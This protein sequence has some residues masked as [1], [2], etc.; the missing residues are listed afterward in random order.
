MENVKAFLTNILKKEIRILLNEDE[1]KIRVVGNV[2]SLTK[3]DKE[4]I[5]NYK[6]DLLKI[7][8][9]DKSKK[10]GEFVSIEKLDDSAC[11]PISDAQRRL[12]VLGQFEN[13]SIAYNMPFDLLLQG[14]YEIEHFEKAVH[15]T[16]ERHEIL[17][18]I[19][20][21]DPANP[22]DGVQQWVISKADFAFKIN[23]L[24][25][26]GQEKRRTMAETYIQTDSI[27]AF[28]FENGPLI[29]ATLIQLEE[30][31][32]VFY[33]NTHHI[34]SDG[35]SGQILRRDVFAFYEAFKAN[36]NPDLPVLNIQYRDYSSWQLNQLKSEGFKS[37]RKFWLSELGG[38]E[39]PL[40]DLPTTKQRPRL[41]TN[42]GQSLVTYFNSDL[43]KKIKAFSHERGGTLFMGMLASLNAIL[44]RYTHQKDIIIGSPIAGREHSD[45]QNQIGYYSNTLA[46]RNN[47]NPQD[48]FNTLFASVKDNT[49]NSYAHQMFPFDRLVEELDLTRDT[50]RNAV[51]DVMLVLQ[52][53]KE[54]SSDFKLKQEDED[55]IFDFGEQSSKFDLLFGATEMGEHLELSVGFNT[56]VYER[57]MIESF[58]IHYKT[59]LSNLLEA[60]EQPIGKVDFLTDAERHDLV[61]GLNNTHA[62]FEQKTVMQLFEEQVLRTPDKIVLEFENVAL[63]YIELNERC[64]IMANF[65]KAHYKIGRSTRLIE[66]EQNE[67]AP[68]EH[69]KIGVMLER[70]AESVI[71]MIGV[72]KTGACYVPID[73]N[74]PTERVKF[75]MQD[76]DIG[77][78]ISESNLSDKHGIEQEKIFSLNSLNW[79]EGNAV[80]PD[81]VNEL[82]DGSF[83]I[84]TSGS[85]G[86]PKGVLQTHLMMT[87]LIQW[88]IHHSGLKSGLKYLQ[89]A[90][91]SFD[92]SLHDVFF[93]VC[94]GGS[95]YVVKESSRLDYPTLE[96]EIIDNKIEVLSLPFS[97]LN[98]FSREI[99]LN[100]LENHCIQPVVSNAEQLYVSTSLTKFLVD[101]PNIDLHNHYGPSE[102]HVIA[103]HHMSAPLGN[104]V[105]RSPVGRPVSNGSAY[106]LDEFQNLVPKGVLGELYFGGDTLALGYLNRADLTAEKFIP[107]PFVQGETVYRSGD[108]GRW[109]PD[110]TLEFVGR[111]DDQIKIRGFR[112]ELGEIEQALTK[113]SEIEAVNVVAKIVSRNKG[114]NDQKNHGEKELVAYIVSRV[115]QN[116]NNLRKYLKEM[117]PDYMIPAFYV[118]LD[119]LPL[120]SNGKVDKRALP[121]PEGSEMASGTEYIAPRTDTE[122]KLVQ[123][124]EEVLVK[125]NIGVRDDFFALGGHSLKAMKLV[126]KI[127][128][129]LQSALKIGNI[130]ISPTIEDLSQI[131]DFALNQKKLKQNSTN[132]KEIE[133]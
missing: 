15:A 86:K 120:T 40:L 125:E 117:L 61:V 88:D 29:R 126:S 21:E 41:K 95:V 19:F 1:T 26:R 90:S 81:H 46:L 65:L 124:W 17:R 77:I 44:Y 96:K 87:T 11:Y 127:N 52:N 35:W 57:E 97:A 100:T 115:T 16:I 98:A 18:T 63:T 76:S 128:Q 32:Y 101:N 133:L 62:D 79:N 92:A 42:N 54:N 78:L 102:T 108:L 51:F 112:V 89:Y 55:K 20:K 4:G 38:G 74:Y 9:K 103:G 10:D 82:A 93:S 94:A 5:A 24:D 33:W 45:L 99:D 14:D 58:I 73:H 43:T 110:G 50:S 23:R 49:I 3:E 85:T 104:L 25:Y 67:G 116:T 28:D 75:I 22:D 119:E 121:D 69:K 109:L 39:L 123:I 114:K 131:I 2:K 59:L 122:H 53:N 80:N 13:R 107:N 132:L 60:P 71:A 111:M 64:N 6:E 34:I 48:S 129:E 130:F 7:L 83:V 66:P 72:M 36:T 113:H 118:Q 47:I 91:L 70:S 30:D 105:P 37:H 27:K 8:K 106:I 84:Y 56:D 31:E 68:I 12:W